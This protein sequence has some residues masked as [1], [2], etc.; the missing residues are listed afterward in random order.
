MWDLEHSKLQEKHQ[1]TK[2][3]L[4]EAFLLH[5]HQ[6]AERHRRVLSLAQTYPAPLAVYITAIAGVV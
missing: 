5:G 6:M 3:Q 2:K 1:V 4:K